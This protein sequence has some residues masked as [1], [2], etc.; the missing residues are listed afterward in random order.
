MELEI[1][2]KQGIKTFDG[3]L[4]NILIYDREPNGLKIVAK[5]DCNHLLLQIDEKEACYF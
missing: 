4:Y 5:S 2:L 3:T 1:P